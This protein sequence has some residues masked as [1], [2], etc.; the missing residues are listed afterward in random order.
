MRSSLRHKSMF[1]F[2]SSPVLFSPLLSKKEKQP[3]TNVPGGD[4]ATPVR[5]AS[6]SK[7]SGRAEGAVVLE[8]EQHW[9]PRRLPLYCTPHL[10]STF[11]DLCFNLC[12]GPSERSCSPSQ[13]MAPFSLTSC[14][15]PIWL[16][17]PSVGDSTSLCVPSALFQ[18][19]EKPSP[20]SGC[21]WP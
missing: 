18:E 6:I 4:R 16:S 5:D 12:F 17:S 21:D 11:L 14:V 8:T 3:F 20:H 7:L 1:D 2:V 9:A 13:K 19:L 10:G 15:C